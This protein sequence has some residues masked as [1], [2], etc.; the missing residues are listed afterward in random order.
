LEEQLESAMA[1][2]MVEVL[3]TEAAVLAGIPVLEEMVV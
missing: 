2:E 3:Q 1:V